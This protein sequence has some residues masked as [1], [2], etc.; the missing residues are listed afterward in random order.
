MDLAVAQRI[1]TQNGSRSVS[2][3]SISGVVLFGP[4]ERG[5]A[6]QP[7]AAGCQ[8]GRPALGGG[9]CWLGVVFFVSINPCL[10]G[11][12]VSACVL[13]QVSVFVLGG[14]ALGLVS[15]FFVGSARCFLVVPLF[16]LVLCFRCWFSSVFWGFTF[17]FSVFWGFVSVVF[18]VFW[19]FT[20]VFGFVL[21]FRYPPIFPL[22][23]AGLG[24]GFERI[25]GRG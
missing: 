13:L 2:G 11:F 16:W 12:W 8:G 19:G 22:E 23:P 20:V 14:W 24:F 7:E 1:G 3:N 25:P 5:S 10:W 15:G 4:F 9:V 6:G 21:C 18:S 17:V